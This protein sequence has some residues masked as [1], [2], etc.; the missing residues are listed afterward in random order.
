MYLNCEKKKKKK[1]EKRE[2]LG[3]LQLSWSRMRFV[4]W[5]T[6]HSCI[7]IRLPDIL[8]QIQSDFHLSCRVACGLV[9]ITSNTIPLRSVR[10]KA[11]ICV[12]NPSQRPSMDWMDYWHTA[13]NRMCGVN[14]TYLSN[15]CF[16]T[17]VSFM[18]M[19]KICITFPSS[20]FFKRTRGG[21]YL[22]LEI[23]ANNQVIYFMLIIH[24]LNNESGCLKPLKK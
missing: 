21:R 8:L 14:A 24:I 3:P 13:Y 4:S 10:Q 9:I 11:P 1:K 12:V 5:K 19:Y 15:V 16:L 23:D 20:W 2:N 17:Y 22:N 18:L 7:R 6:C